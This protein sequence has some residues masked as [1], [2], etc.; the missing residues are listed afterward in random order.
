[1]ESIEVSFVVTSNYSQN[2]TTFKHL[3]I[4]TPIWATVSCHCYCSNLLIGHPAFILISLPSVCY[5][6]AESSIWNLLKRFFSLLKSL[7]WLFTMLSKSK[8]SYN[9]LPSSVWSSLL[10]ITSPTLFSITSL[11]PRPQRA[12]Y[13]SL[14]FPEHIRH[15]CFETSCLCLECSSLSHLLG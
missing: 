12:T 13:I 4:I 10:P 8:H 3:S 15:F 9:Y 6:A 7:Q 11:L 2:L 14:L 5:A 1:M